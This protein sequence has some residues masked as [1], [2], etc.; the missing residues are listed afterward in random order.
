M[1]KEIEEG[2]AGFPSHFVSPEIKKSKEYSF[3]WLSAINGSDRSTLGLG[4]K[5]LMFNGDINKFA[6]NRSYARGDQS[7]DRYKPILGVRKK[8]RKDPDA[9]SWKVLDW[10]ILD[11]ASKFINLLEGRLISQNNDVGVRA[12]DKYA[13]NAKRQKKIQLQEYVINKQYLDGVSKSTGIQFS[14]PVNTDVVPLPESLGDIDLHM[15]MF[16]KEEYCMVMQDLLKHINEQ[17]DYNEVLRGIATDLIEVKIAGTKTYQVGRNI[18]RR[19]VNIERVVSSPSSKPNYEDVQW[20]G[21]YWDLTIGELKELAGSQFTEEQYRD[22]AQNKSNQQFGAIDSADVRKFYNDNYCYPWD[23]TKI[24][25]LDAIWF[26]PDQKIYQL[27]KDRDGNAVQ[28]EKPYSWWANLSAKGVTE[29][30]FNE[31]NENPVIIEPKNNVYQGMLIVGTKYCFNYGLCK[32]M[33]KDEST[34]GKALSPFTFYSVKKSIVEIIRP[35][36]DNIQINWLQYQHHAAKSRPAGL[37]IEYTALQDI[38][39]HG[40]K[41]KAMTPKQALELYFDTGVLLWRRKDIAGNLSNFRPI[42]EL[43]NG[44]NDAATK[45]FTNVVNNIDLLRNMI[46]ENELTDASTPNSEMGKHVATLATGGSR[47][48]QKY[49]HYAFD[50]INLGTQRRT[51]MYVS[52]MA[53]NGY[54]P[55]YS[56]VIGEESIAF[57]AIM[58]DVS[59]HSLGVYLMKQPTEEMK[60][61]LSIYVQNG[62]KNGTL[63]EEEAWE[64]EN[65]TNI[66]KAINLMKKY[67]QDKIRAK[68][69]D[70]ERISKI[71]ETRNVNVARAAEEEK[72]ITL[73]KEKEVKDA[74]AWSAAKAEVW[75]SKQTVADEAFILNLKSKLARN[76]TLTKEEERRLTELSK[77]DAKGQFD[78]QIAS[79]NA[80]K[81]A[82]SNQARGNSK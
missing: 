22:I 15:E 21:E 62:T 30:S 13:L 53:S 75:K 28:I 70:D 19:K 25:V 65:E 36:L 2:V 9:Q 60:A 3:R 42:N 76:E 41:G 73:D 5:N 49:L 20:V 51:A 59:M 63:L 6:E 52:N 39:L 81:A 54:A 16:Y 17:D 55:E 12:I 33:L 57:M 80:E 45:H 24:T 14:Q 35:I 10:T 77:I 61:K 78:L 69:K 82:K 11:V 23:S 46:G 26:S 43:N 29:K 8:T 1:A 44:L 7:I 58:E 68:E 18:R 31:R 64:I 32:D 4:N 34:K 74:I 79:I 27:K 38:R 50:Q 71:E 66:Y 72:R 37:D 56:E 47:D 40:A 67:R 48:A